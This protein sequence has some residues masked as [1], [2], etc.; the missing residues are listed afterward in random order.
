MKLNGR[1]KQQ[2]REWCT[3]LESGV[4]RQNREGFLNRGGSFCCLGVACALFIP[5]N[6][7]EKTTNSYDHI[8]KNEI[9]GCYT[10][11]QK[12]APKWLKQID[13][14]FYRRTGNKL[15]QLNDNGAPFEYLAKKIRKTYLKGE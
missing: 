13:Q 8:S 15:S 4:F 12:A 3:V 1:S 14:D 5:E 9:N 10:Y 2:I 6:K 7:I 11:S